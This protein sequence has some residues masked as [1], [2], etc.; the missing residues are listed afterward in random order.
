MLLLLLRS[1]AATQSRHAVGQVRVIPSRVGGKNRIRCCRVYAIPRHCQRLVVDGRL[2]GHD[3][4]LQTCLTVLRR[5]AP[6]N[7]IA[8]RYEQ[9]E[10]GGYVIGPAQVRLPILASPRSDAAC[11]ARQ[12][13][14]V[15]L[16]APGGSESAAC[17]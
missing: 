2:H 9:S 14:R 6:L 15:A 3:E 12:R 10:G 5:F 11:R 13:P 8:V 7:V 1:H 16:A 17:R 4:K